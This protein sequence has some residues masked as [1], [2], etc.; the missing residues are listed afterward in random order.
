MIGM[1]LRID[2]QPRDAKILTL[3]VGHSD[4]YFMVY[5]FYPQ[6][7][8]IV[9]HHMSEMVLSGIANDVIL[10]VGYFVM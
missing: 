8:S 2:G 9:I 1:T 6:Y 7:Y 3:C 10:F 4:L 5:A